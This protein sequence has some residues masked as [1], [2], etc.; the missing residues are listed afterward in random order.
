[1]LWINQICFYSIYSN[2]IQFTHTQIEAIRAGMQPGLTMV[3]TDIIACLI[4]FVDK[5]SSLILDV[6]WKSYSVF[7]VMLKLD[8]FKSTMW[9]QTLSSFTLTLKNKNLGKEEIVRTFSDENFSC[10]NWRKC[11]LSLVEEF[12]FLFPVTEPIGFSIYLFY[13]TECTV[14]TAN[15]LW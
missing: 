9:S 15:L 4:L 10:I 6:L 12:V 8:Y 2:T 14:Y 3:L 1:M 11:T 7:R 5:L 13:F